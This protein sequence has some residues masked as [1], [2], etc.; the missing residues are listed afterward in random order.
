MEANEYQCA[1]C[2]KVYEKVWSD[3]DADQEA[4]ALW[5][6]EHASA[7]PEVFAVICDDCF[8]QRSLAEVEAMGQAYQQ[9]RDIIK[10]KEGRC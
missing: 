10:N 7:A 4:L 9:W 6:V 5:G 8:R 3:E 2:H 1:L